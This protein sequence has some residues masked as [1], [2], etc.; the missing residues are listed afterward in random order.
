MGHIEGE[1]RYQR[2]LLAASL[3]EMVSATHMVR[4]VDAFIGGLDLRGLGFAEV[5]A[6]ETQ[7]GRG[8]GPVL[9]ATPRSRK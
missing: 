2:H 9:R 4:V 5:E 1:S 7:T 6:A 8:H 3:D